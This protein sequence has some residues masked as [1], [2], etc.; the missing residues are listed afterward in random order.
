MG[1]PIPENVKG[2]PEASAEA[3]D[4]AHVTQARVPSRVAGGTQ[5]FLAKT[6]PAGNGSS[7]LL[8]GGIG[9]GLC[10]FYIPLQSLSSPYILTHTIY[11][12][13]SKHTES[14]AKHSTA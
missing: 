12:P 11:I 2:Y 13:S 4:F 6:C 1:T 10:P 5:Y 8:I 3:C 14:G 9:R 7:L